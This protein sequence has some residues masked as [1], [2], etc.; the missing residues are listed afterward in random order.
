M[1]QE[2]T[3]CLPCYQVLRKVN[4]GLAKF[5]ELYAE[6][7]GTQESSVCADLHG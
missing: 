7:C 4:M 3:R 1:T 6:V 5:A 2:V